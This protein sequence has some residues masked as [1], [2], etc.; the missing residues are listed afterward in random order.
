MLYTVVVYVCMDAHV[1]FDTDVYADM[2]TGIDVEVDV[3]MVGVCMVIATTI[4]IQ[5]V[6][7]VWTFFFFFI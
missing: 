4:R 1:G 5:M 7:V 3:N 2:Y 6:A